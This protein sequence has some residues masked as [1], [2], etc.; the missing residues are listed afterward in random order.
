MNVTAAQLRLLLSL[1]H[2][3]T[4]RYW[5]RHW[6]KLALLVGIVA[7]GVG[8]FLAIGLA[9]RAATESFDAFAKTVAGQSQIVVTASAGSLRTLD[10][11]ALRRA[12]LDTEASL[13]PQLITNARLVGAAGPTDDDPVFTFIGTDL[14]A[15]S[16]FLLRMQAEQTYWKRDRQSERPANGFYSESATAANHGWKAGSKPQFLIGDKTVELLWLGNLPSVDGQNETGA[17]AVVMDLSD[18]RSILNRPDAID[19]VDIVLPETDRERATEAVV[20]RIQSVNPGYWIVETNEERGRAGATMTNALR[21]NLRALSALSLCIAICLVFQ[22][23]DSAV[24]RRQGEV[25]IL[26]SLGLSPRLARSLWLTDAAFI[27]LLGGVGG[28]ALGSLLAKGSTAMVR[29]TVETLYHRSGD[30]VS[31][32]SLGEALLAA[33]LSLVACLVAGWWPARQAARAPLIEVMRQGAGRSSYRRG[34]YLVAVASM[35]ALAAIAY[36]LPPVPAANGHAIPV[37][38]YALTIALIGAATAIGCLVLDGLGALARP[39]G[40]FSPSLR[41]ALSQFRQPVTRHRLALAGV[42]I[43]IGMTAAMIFLIGSFESTVRSWIGSTLQAD[44]F[45]RSRAVSSVHDESRIAPELF[46]RLMADPRVTDG[47]SIATSPVRIENLPTQLI[48]YD[49][50]YIRRVS[51]FTWISRAPDLGKLDT[52]DF[53][54]VNEPFANR[55]RKFSGDEVELNT[56]NGNAI[57]RIIGVYADYGNE[58]G[59]LGIDQARYAELTGDRTLR[60]IALHAKSQTDIVALQQDISAAYPALNVV[61]NRFL[62]EETLRIFNRVFSITYA[63]ELVGLV[64]S[65]AGLG[66][67][68]ASLLIERRPE[69]SALQRIGVSPAQIARSALWEGLALAVLGVATGLV[70]GG[71]LGLVLVFVINKQSFGW[72][73]AVSIPWIQLLGLAALTLAGAALVS[74]LVGRWAGR[75]PI[76]HEE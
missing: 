49:T 29:Q 62:R 60:A 68:L 15:A 11:K 48:G 22:A 65:V 27:G 37:G 17:Q 2:R 42:T 74:Y 3:F 66:S 24:A 36:N 31:N 1:L 21:M 28:V 6:I 52:G 69:I 19:R 12:L 76:L 30:A 61:T 33:T 51:R 39:L 26:L 73:L 59:N 58:N 38:G 50:D 4:L 64:I 9:N 67:M 14:L 57:F 8:S 25:S 46:S 75:L 34:A 41:V 55:F 35:L 40:L 43:S 10:A 44:L 20:Q 71:L 32:F 7:L 63:L 13:F 56:P 45:I 23:M 18:L 16:N 47:G 72:T 53:A 5:Q 54:I 70:L